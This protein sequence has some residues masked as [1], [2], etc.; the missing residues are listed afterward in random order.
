MRFYNVDMQGKFFSQRGS[1]N[2]PGTGAAD[3]GRVFY[4][5]TSEEMYYHDAAAWIK[6]YS[7]N[8]VS[9]LVSDLDSSFLR[10]DQNDDNGA[11]RL[12]LGQLYVGAYQMVDHTTGIIPTGR[13]SGTYN[14]NITGS[15]RYA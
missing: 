7:E 11:Y 2:P 9:D 5:E 8:N 10:K 6:V 14:I 3:E 15:A 1:A 13:L 12:T 4:N